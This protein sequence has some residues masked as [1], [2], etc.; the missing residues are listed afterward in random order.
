VY[1]EYDNGWLTSFQ[2]NPLVEDLKET[3]VS[4]YFP[5]AKRF[6]EVPISSQTLKGMLNL[7]E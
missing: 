4:T 1:V 7:E 3:D 2:T 6:S 5:A